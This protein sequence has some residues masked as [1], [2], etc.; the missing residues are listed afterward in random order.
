MALDRGPHVPALD[1]VW[2]PALAALEDQG[3]LPRALDLPRGAREIKGTVAVAGGGCW[4]SFPPAWHV[5]GGDLLGVTVAPFHGVRLWF[6]G[7]NLN[8]SIR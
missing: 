8:D 4:S 1:C 5:R 2:K 3:C 6:G 7:W